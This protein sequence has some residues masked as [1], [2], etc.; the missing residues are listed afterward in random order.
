VIALNAYRSKSLVASK[1]DVK[2]ADLL[3]QGRKIP[4]L[5]PGND[6]QSDGKSI[7]FIAVICIVLGRA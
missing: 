6:M 5:L 2:A 4:G 3:M 1:D 7:L